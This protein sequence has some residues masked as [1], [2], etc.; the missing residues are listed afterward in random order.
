M[1]TGAHPGPVLAQ[2]ASSSC[3]DLGLQF[4]R[5]EWDLE[6]IEEGTPKHEICRW[7]SRQVPIC[8]GLK[9][10]TYGNIQ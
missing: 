2:V 1:G 6:I 7:G 9:C 8:L 4:Q 3:P 5:V 10:G